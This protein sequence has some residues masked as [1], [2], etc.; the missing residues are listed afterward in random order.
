MAISIHCTHCQHRATAPDHF[1]GRTVRCPSC[2]KTFQVTAQPVA[3]SAS[4]DGVPIARKVEPRSDR[5]TPSARPTSPSAPSPTSRPSGIDKAPT[6]KIDIFDPFGDAEV[7]KPRTPAP[8]PTPVAKTPAPQPPIAKPLPPKAP[9]ARSAPPPP[10]ARSPGRKIA[11]EEFDDDVE[12]YVL[13]D[14]PARKGPIKPPGQGSSR[15]PSRSSAKANPFEAED[16]ELL[17]D[18]DDIVID[19]DAVPDVFDQ[20]MYLMNQKHF[21]LSE[22]YT[23]LNEEETPLIWVVRK[24]HWMKQWAA[25]GSM[26]LT[27]AGIV[28]LSAIIA[29][30]IGRATGNDMGK[31]VAVGIPI[32]FVLA[33]IPA[34]AVFIIMTPKRHIEF[35]YDE[36]L[37]E[38]I[39]EVKQNE[40]VAIWRQTFTVVGANKKQIGHFEKLPFFDIIRR[41]WRCFDADGNMDYIATEDSLIKALLR[42]FFNGGIVMI[43]LRTNFIILRL[44]PNSND[45]KKIGEFN[46][47]FTIVDKYVLDLRKDPRRKFD[48]RRAL[49]LAVLLDT[50]ERR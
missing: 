37:T 38:K 26:I 21:S 8:A 46:R 48:R 34:L 5:A 42:R 4:P 11:E 33:I 17:D 20:D 45:R 41:S 47:K 16:I 28:A 27:F 12:E 25:L 19:D 44:D 31:A 40:K 13:S 2:Q 23:I 1:A 49:A 30:F 43:F 7:V 39:L 15:P 10:V 14:T 35:F 3:P 9:P 50:G 32:G 24:V 22:K 18:E 29:A 6:D 36:D